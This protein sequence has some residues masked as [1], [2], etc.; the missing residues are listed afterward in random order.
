MD[1]RYFVEVNGQA[2]GPAAVEDLVEWAAQGR[3]DDST[4]LR[5]ETS[6][7]RVLA[8]Q[9]PALAGHLSKPAA[10]APSMP[11]EPSSGIRTTGG[12]RPVGGGS[13]GSAPAAETDQPANPSYANPYAASQP[14]SP[15]GAPSPPYGAPQSPYG[16][17]QGPVGVAPRPYLDGRSYGGVGV[18]DSGTGASAQLPAELRGMNF[19]AFF[20]SFWWSIFNKT[21]IG[22]LILVPFL[23]WLMAFVL[24]VK[25][26]EWAWQN[27][28]FESVEEFRQVQKS[29]TNWSLGLLAVSVALN[30]LSWLLGGGHH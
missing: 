3:L 1:N 4:I 18:N 9:L 23:G 2:Y 15:Y 27:R 8:G 25:G 28:R 17:P 11:T 30:L 7:D 13:F 5:G 21:Y 16:A 19:G 14:Q 22:L 26:N 6:G 10:P 20:M 24:L 29:W 12:L